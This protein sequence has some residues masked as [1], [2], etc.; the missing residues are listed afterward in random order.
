[1]SLNRINREL[2]EMTRDPPSNCSAGPVDNNLYHWHSTIMGPNESPCE[3]GVYF[4]DIQF[5]ADYP[6]KPPKIMF[7]TKIFH[8]NINSEGGSIISPST[9]R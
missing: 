3:G 1:M 4:L 2:K 7:T 6:F 9:I 5:P 8:P